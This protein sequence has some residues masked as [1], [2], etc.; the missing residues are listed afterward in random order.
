MDKQPVWSPDGRKIAF[1]SNLDGDTEIFVMDAEGDNQK[2]ITNNE[3][4][5]HSPSW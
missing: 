3:S 2:R 5:D 1:V 4:A